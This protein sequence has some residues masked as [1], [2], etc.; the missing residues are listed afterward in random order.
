MRITGK[1]WNF[2]YFVILVSYETFCFVQRIFV[3]YVVSFTKLGSL[4][5]RGAGNMAPW[6]QRGTSRRQ[7]RKKAGGCNGNHLWSQNL[8][9]RGVRKCRRRRPFEH[10]Y[11]AGHSRQAQ[12]RRHRRHPAGPSPSPSPNWEPSPRRRRVTL[13]HRASNMGPSTTSSHP[14]RWTASL[15]SLGPSVAGLLVQGR[16][17]PAQGASVHRRRQGARK[18]S[19]YCSPMESIGAQFCIE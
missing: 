14:V 1:S 8:E 9:P 7:R 5:R 10:N 15:G 3:S 16:C 4:C 18:L 19:A 13:G 6:L 12:V 2:R 11:P 17:S